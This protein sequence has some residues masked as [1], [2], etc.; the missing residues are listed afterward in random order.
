[1]ENVKLV[2][3]DSVKVVS[4]AELIKKLLAEGWMV[5]SEETETKPKA[6]KGTK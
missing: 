5:Y 4:N 2:K 3:G 6:K 1:M